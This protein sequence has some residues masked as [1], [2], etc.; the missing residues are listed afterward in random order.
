[1]D[2]ILHQVTC[3]LRFPSF[4]PPGEHYHRSLIESESMDLPITI[5][6]KTE[7]HNE[8]GSEWTEVKYRIHPSSVPFLTEAFRMGLI[9]A[10]ETWKS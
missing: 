2:S 3:S 9:R 8:E 6:E 7:H 1:M 4:T 10:S 5:E